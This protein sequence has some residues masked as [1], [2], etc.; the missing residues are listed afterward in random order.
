MVL[1]QIINTGFLL[2]INCRA[3]VLIGP[4]HGADAPLCSSVSVPERLEFVV[5]KYAEHTHE[6]WSLDKVVQCAPDPDK[7]GCLSVVRLCLC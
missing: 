2:V 6:K 7:C 3:S 5:N 4:P 1:F